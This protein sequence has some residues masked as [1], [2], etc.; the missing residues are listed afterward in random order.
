MRP[1]VAHVFFA[2]AERLLASAPDFRRWLSLPEREHAERFR[3]P[4]H[5]AQY[6]ATRVL[7]RGVLGGLLGRPPQALDF[8]LHPHGRPALRPGTAA[9]DFNASRSRASVALVVTSGEACGVDVEDTSR[10]VDVLSIAR[11]FAPAERALLQ[12]SAGE[13]RQLHFFQLWTLKEATL[14]ALGTG[15]TLSLGACAFQLQPSGP[16]SVTFGGGLQEAPEAWCFLQ[17]AVDSTHLVAVAVRSAQPLA[18]V[19]HDD[20]ETC[21]AVGGVP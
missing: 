21:A 19:F 11:T 13:E 3:Q 2:H 6:R 4:G 16:P 1:G 15:L 14:K 20:A 7:V 10:T 5:G 18:F 8:V 17:R 9:L 12:A